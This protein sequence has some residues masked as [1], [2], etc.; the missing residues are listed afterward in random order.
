[1]SKASKSKPLPEHFV[2][3]TGKISGVYA[4]SFHSVWGDGTIGL[5]EYR[6]EPDPD[7]MER[8]LSDIRRHRAVLVCELQHL[9][10]A[11]DALLNPL[12]RRPPATGKGEGG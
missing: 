6:R 9:Q 5:T 10:R 11:E 1:M 12:K 3:A 7:E 2:V 8:I 4:D